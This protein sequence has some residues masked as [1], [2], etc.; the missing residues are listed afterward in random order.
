MKTSG[1]ADCAG[2]SSSL[3]DGP[4]AYYDGACPLCTREIAFCRRQAG[5]SRIHWIDVSRLG[6]NEVAPDLSNN[7]A[8]ARFHVRDI[9]G[10]LVSGGAAFVLVWKNLPRFRWLCTIF[11]PRPFTWVLDRVY[12]AFLKIRP[13]LQSLVRARGAGERLRL[14]RTPGILSLCDANTTVAYCLYAPSGEIEYLFVHPGFRRRGHAR[15]LLAMV[16]A[17]TGESL[18]FNPPISPLGRHLVQSYDRGRH[19][20]D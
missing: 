3:H 20:T 2:A 8:L 9:D 15:R 12:A 1:V 11:A 14:K 13:R 5:A 6:G 19:A 18:R 16:E 7:A 4:I 17:E 10:S